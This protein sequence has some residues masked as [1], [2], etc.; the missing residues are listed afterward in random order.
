MNATGIPMPIARIAAR[1]RLRS[2]SSWP[3]AEGPTPCP[4]GTEPGASI[5]ISLLGFRDF[6]SEPIDK[7]SV[8]GQRRMRRQQRLRDFIRL[9]QQILALV[10]RRRVDAAPEVAL[11]ARRVAGGEPRHR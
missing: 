5:D 11:G 9:E 7:R 2:R 10:A 3:T 1:R 6:G 4:G 8:S